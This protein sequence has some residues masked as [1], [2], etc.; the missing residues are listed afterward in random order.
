MEGGHLHIG[1]RWSLLG[2]LSAPPHWDSGVREVGR[3]LGTST[4]RHSPGVLWVISGE[5]KQALGF[6]LKGNPK[7]DRTSV[8][9][10]K[11]WVLEGKQT[12]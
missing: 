4:G 1:L 7:Q 3:T 12:G 8:E 9:A 10:M 11:Y 5:G 6:R 2:I